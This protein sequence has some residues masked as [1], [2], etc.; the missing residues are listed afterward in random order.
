MLKNKLLVSVI[1]SVIPLVSFANTTVIISNQ[2]ITAPGWPSVAEIEIK[3]ETLNQ[4]FPLQ[5][6]EEKQIDLADKGV[7]NFNIYDYI[8]GNGGMQ[9]SSNCKNQTIQLKEGHVIRITI[10]GSPSNTLTW[11]SYVSC[12][13][14]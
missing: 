2:T 5:A 3:T 8:F 13:V 6:Q 7:M 1:C 14:E 10:N 9:V 11:G 4:K 12:K